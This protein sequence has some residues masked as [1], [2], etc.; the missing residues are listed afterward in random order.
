MNKC[1]ATVPIHYS[2]CYKFNFSCATATVLLHISVVG[3]KPQ[4]VIVH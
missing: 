4:Y 3:Y 2:W 1:A